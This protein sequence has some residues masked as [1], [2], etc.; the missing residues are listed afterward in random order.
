MGAD[1]IRELRQPAHYQGVRV[2]PAVLVQD[3]GGGLPVAG[4]ELRLSHGIFQPRREAGA[5]F[6]LDG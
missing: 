2:A 3:H 4:G 1:Q 5:G 6:D